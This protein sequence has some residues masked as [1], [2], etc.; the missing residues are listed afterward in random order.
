MGMVKSCSGSNLRRLFR[1][2]SAAIW[3]GERGAWKLM[4]VMCEVIAAVK[5]G[6]SAEEGEVG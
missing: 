1:G 5:D 6:V 3:K 2:A 4:M